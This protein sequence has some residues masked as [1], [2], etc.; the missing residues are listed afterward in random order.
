MK[1]IARF[2]VIGLAMI[3]NIGLLSV[4]AMAIGPS[5]NPSSATSATPTMSPT[6]NFTPTPNA[7]PTA[8]PTKTPTPTANA[9]GQPSSNPSSGVRTWLE[10]FAYLSTSKVGIPNVNVTLY[11]NGNTGVTVKTDLTGHY[12]FPSVYPESASLKAQGDFVVF[13]IKT[14][15]WLRPGK[16]VYDIKLEVVSSN[17]ISGELLYKKP[18]VIIKIFEVKSRKLIGKTIIG[19]Q[20]INFE[21]VSDALVPGVDFSVEPWLGDTKLIGTPATVKFSATNNQ[22][23]SVSL[24]VDNVAVDNVHKVD[25]VVVDYF[26]YG[27]TE[28]LVS[29]A[30]VKLDLYPKTHLSAKTNKKGIAS[31]KKV[32]SGVYTVTVSASGY[33]TYTTTAVLYNVPDNTADIIHVAM[34]PNSVST[35][36]KCYKY[37]QTNVKEFWFCGYQAKTTYTSM[38]A[39][40]KAVDEQ[41]GKLRAA[42]PKYNMLPLQV[43]VNSDGNPSVGYE[44]SE[45]GHNES[46]PPNV[47]CMSAL[48]HPNTNGPNLFAERFEITASVVQ[49]YGTDVTVHAVI[50]EFGHGIDLR[51]SGTCDTFSSDTGLFATVRALGRFLDPPY[52]TVIKDS[53]YDNAWKSFGHPKDGN[54][55]TYASAFH[56]GIVHMNDYSKN[57]NDT[58]QIINDILMKTVDLSLQP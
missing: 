23:I 58:G 50:H 45:Y 14:I 30:T 40:W 38:L 51:K 21:Y 47:K 43:V 17:K 7:T 52:F 4:P 20:G 48:P 13:P 3:I 24:Q 18:G 6:A 35:D 5:S 28:K 49:K 25:V 33:K 57:A 39:T 46:S 41:I 32:L 15:P 10:G 31:F 16:N 26:D 2:L 11:Q 54:T 42:Y 27:P 29:N 44:Y 34:T 19:P 22:T 37:P 56:D 36:G 1:K 8:T 12:I 9:S 53:T 55:E